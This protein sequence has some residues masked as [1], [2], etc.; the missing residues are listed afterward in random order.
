M[1]MPEFPKREDLLSREEAVSSIIASI[2]MEEAAL[3]LILK[4]ESE[5]IKYVTE[6]T[7]NNKH[8]DMK[9]L[10]KV[11]DSAAALIERINDMQLILKN[12][13]RI[14]CS[15]IPC[16]HPKPDPPHP[17]PKPKPC[18]PYPLCPPG[19][20]G[21]SLEKSGLCTEVF[22]ASAKYRWSHGTTLRLEKKSH[23]ENGSEIVHHSCDTLIRLPMCKKYRI[24]LDLDLVN[25]SQCYVLIE[26]KITSGNETVFLKEYPYDPEKRHI[27]LQDKPISKT[28]LKRKGSLLSVRLIS[29]KNLE[30]RRGNVFVTEA[31]DDD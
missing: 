20:I 26:V 13:L 23:C 30:I 29:P 24:E 27:C 8:A 1:S 6:Y 12:K 10:L 28:P 2:A 11:N 18:P 15:C 3:S 4:A 19:L 5:K 22:S 16:P 31:L 14:A 21:P 17:T 25:V 7:K 9:M